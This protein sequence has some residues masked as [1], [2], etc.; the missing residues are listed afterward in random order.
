MCF[1]SWLFL[2]GCQ[3]QFKWLT[4]KNRSPKWPICVD[5]D[6]KPN[7]LTHSLTS[8]Q[9]T[10]K[11]SRAKS[12]V[13]Q[14]N[15]SELHWEGVKPK[16]GLEHYPLCSILEHLLRLWVHKIVRNWLG[17]CSDLWSRVIITRCSPTALQWATL[18]FAPDNIAV[19]CVSDCVEVGH[20][21]AR[22]P[23]DKWVVLPRAGD[24]SSVW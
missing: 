24:G 22:N 9:L 17:V 21:H 1:V 23:R 20:R 6:V 12:E 15:C 7:Q 14:K 16:F 2:L 4:G 13:S 18:Q 19:V 5:G 11:Y 3:Y 10:E 8:L